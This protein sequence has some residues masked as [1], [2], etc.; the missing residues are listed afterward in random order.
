MFSASNSIFNLRRLFIIKI[1]IL[2]F[3][4][5]NNTFITPYSCYVLVTCCNIR[6][7]IFKSQ[8]LRKQVDKENKEVTRALHYGLQTTAESKYVSILQLYGRDVL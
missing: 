4:T 7:L 6:I 1:I 3:E 5:N 8:R 2:Q